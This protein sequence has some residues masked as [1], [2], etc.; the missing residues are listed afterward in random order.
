MRPYLAMIVLVSF[1]VFEAGCDEN[2]STLAGPTP[3]LEPT[4]ASIQREIFEST[5][6]S[7]RLACVNCHTDQGRTPAGLMNLRPEVAYDQIVNVRSVEQPALLRVQ[8]GDPDAS[9]LVHKLE[10]RVGISGRR[11]PFTPPYMSEG[12]ILILRRWIEIGAPRN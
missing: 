1:A 10:G 4:F 9:Y 7:G 5:D 2:L 11:M 3:R 8:P 12:Q 6:S